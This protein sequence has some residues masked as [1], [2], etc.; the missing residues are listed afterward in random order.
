MKTFEERQI[1]LDQEY[2]TKIITQ[3]SINDIF[4]YPHLFRG[5]VKTSLGYIF[6]NNEYNEWK[7]NILNIKLP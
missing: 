4:L 6:T 1:I 3:D 5:S 2:Q 7:K